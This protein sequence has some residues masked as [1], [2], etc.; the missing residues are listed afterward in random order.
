M[1]QVMTLSD[2]AEYLRCHPSTV[3]RLLKEKRIPAFRVGTDWRFTREAIDDW[4]RNRMD[5]TIGES[6]R[7]K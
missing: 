3:Y 5:A 2:V 1:P 6:P 4:M 7:K